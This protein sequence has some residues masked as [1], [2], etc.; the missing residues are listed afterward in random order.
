[1]ETLGFIDALY[2]TGVTGTVLGYGDITP[3]T[4]GLRILTFFISG[5]GFLLVTAAI[6]YLLSV[7]NGSTERN[8][9]ALR[10][11]SATDHTGDGVT[12]VEQL[13]KRHDANGLRDRIEELAMELRSVQERFHQFP[14]LDLF[15]RSRR[16]SHNPEPMLYAL[17]EGSIAIA[18]LARK[19]P[20]IE[21]T[22]HELDDAVFQCMLLLVEQHF[23]KQTRK[24]F[25]DPNPTPADRQQLH[26]IR[27][28]LEKNLEVD[29]GE[30][31]EEETTLCLVARTR[32]FSQGL[33]RVTSWD[34]PERDY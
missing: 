28:R 18:V 15:Y 9:L 34:P 2:F 4:P 33:A 10:V 29:L 19:D 17:A 27:K 23:D 7:V 6:T 5:Y 25:E 8:I 20:H 14:I 24:A 31:Y 22:S 30:E 13:V 11:H 12:M 21:P 32:I 26:N 1:L 16:D 3:L